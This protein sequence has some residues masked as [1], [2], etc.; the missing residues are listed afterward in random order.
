MKTILIL[1]LLFVCTFLV[2]VAEQDIVLSKVE[3]KAGM[4]V[5]EAMESR[6]ASRRYDG[7]EVPLKTISTILWAGYGII[8]EEGAKTVHGYDA[9]SAATSRNRYS[10][11]FGWGSPYL[12]IY[13][14]LKDAA[15]EYLP[16]EHKLKF[17]TNKNLISE[18]GSSGSGAYGVIVIAADFNEMPGGNKGTTRDVAF[19]SAGSAA[20]NMYVAGAAYDIQMLTQVSIEHNK[21]KKGLNLPGEVEPLTILSFGYSK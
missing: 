20:Q 5:I 6:A 16:E 9:V 2:C 12:R 17:I 13:L 21:I 19:L 18:S 14:L 10:I 11:P 3:A 15:Y 4:D 7:R 1:S 8:L